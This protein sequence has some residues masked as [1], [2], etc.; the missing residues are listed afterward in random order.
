MLGAHGVRGDLKIEQMAPDSCFQIG[1]TVVIAG[2]EHKIRQ[3]RTGGR[4]LLVKLSGINDRETARGL[5]DQYL[6]VREDSLAPLPDGEYY[7]FQLIGLTVT[8]SDGGELGTLVDV[9]ATGA[10]DVY[11]IRGP[12]GEV[13]IPATAEV[14]TEIDLKAGTM[15]VD[16]LPGLLPNG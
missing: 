10:A 8:T 14:I 16:P 2:N 4:T 9:L 3:L 15:T 12:L 5:R 11:T 1:A 13:L 6:Q 7:R